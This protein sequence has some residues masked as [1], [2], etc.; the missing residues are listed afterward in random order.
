MQKHDK[1][2]RGIVNSKGSFILC[3]LDIREKNVDEKL[4]ESR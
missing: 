1:M 3:S 4:K 2:Y